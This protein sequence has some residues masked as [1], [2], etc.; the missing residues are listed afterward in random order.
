[1]KKLLIFIVTSVIS[2]FPSPACNENENWVVVDHAK[3]LLE[4]VGEV[5]EIRIGKNNQECNEKLQIS[6]RGFDLFFCTSDIED[7][8]EK[9]KINE[10]S[11]IC[12]T[13]FKT[14]KVC[15]LDFWT[16]IG[17]D[18]Y[19]KDIVF[20]LARKGLFSVKKGKQTID[21]SVFAK[22]KFS[23]EDGG[24]YGEGFFLSKYERLFSRSTNPIW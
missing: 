21:F 17:N 2:V 24:E 6:Y 12:K 19:S 7:E 13:D 22:Y 9:I 11:N 18:S 16:E 10:P 20:S 14:K 5:K 15:V 8:C 4:Y 1:M 23:C 3:C